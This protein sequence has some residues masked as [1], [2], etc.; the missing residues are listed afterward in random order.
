MRIAKHARAQ[1]FGVFFNLRLRVERAA[2]I[3]QVHLAESVQ[4]AVL[5]SP[6]FVQSRGRISLLTL[7][8][9]MSPE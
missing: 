1:L 4:T 6:Q 5:G 9:R 8:N 2:R 7:R 3:V